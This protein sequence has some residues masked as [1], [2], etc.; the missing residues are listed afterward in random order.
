MT[1]TSDIQVEDKFQGEEC[2]LREVY[3]LIVAVKDEIRKTIHEL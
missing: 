2:W 1:S 3:R